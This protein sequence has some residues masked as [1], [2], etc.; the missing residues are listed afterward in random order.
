M[1][2]SGV[3]EVCGMANILRTKTLVAIALV[4]LFFFLQN[5]EHMGLDAVTE[6]AG[7]HRVKQ[8]SYC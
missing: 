1:A 3:S 6:L 4:G 8:S 2:T 5:R 7:S